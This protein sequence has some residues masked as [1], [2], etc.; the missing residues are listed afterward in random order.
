MNEK[1]KERERESDGA[2]SFVL[3]GVRSDWR[4]RQ[5]APA[6]AAFS[7]ARDIGPIAYSR[8]FLGRG[9]PHASRI[10]LPSSLSLLLL[11]SSQRRD[12][13]LYELPVVSAESVRERRREAVGIRAA[14]FARPSADGAAGAIVE[15]TYEAST[16]THL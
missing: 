16:L 13:H 3:R 9:L 12:V 14:L 1:E 2:C 15:G 6:M 11:L 5:V 7:R 8:A 10:R 4:V